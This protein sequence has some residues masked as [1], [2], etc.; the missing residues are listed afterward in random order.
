M[1][2]FGESARKFAACRR[3]GTKRREIYV[4]GP[5]STRPTSL[6]QVPG[7]RAWTTKVPACRGKKGSE[8]T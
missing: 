4:T 5:G 7:S 6:Y 1:H 2:D 3:C 8:G